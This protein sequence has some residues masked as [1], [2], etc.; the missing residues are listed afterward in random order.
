MKPYESQLH[1]I[2]LSE[3]LTHDFVVS[4]NTNYMSGVV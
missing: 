1:H 2:T 4:A 3:H